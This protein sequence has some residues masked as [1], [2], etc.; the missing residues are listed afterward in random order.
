MAEKNQELFDFI[1]GTYKKDED[2]DSISENDF[3]HIPLSVQSALNVTRG[4]SQAIP[5]FRR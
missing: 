1:V 3:D 4:F 2:M 5:N